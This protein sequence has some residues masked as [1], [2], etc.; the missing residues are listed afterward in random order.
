MTSARPIESIHAFDARVDA[1]LEQYRGNPVADRVFNTAST[2][3]DFSVLW[4]LISAARALRGGRNVR[5]SVELSLLLGAESLIVNQGIKRLFKRTRPTASGD[6]RYGVRTPSTSSFPS[7]HAS[8]AFFAATL[9][10]SMTARRLAPMWFGLALIVAMS[11][12]FVRIHHASD[13][14][15]GAAVGLTLGAI[16]TRLRQLWAR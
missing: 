11:R 1:W 4:H 10:T 15:G 12:P 7:G 14:V 8:S 5:Q 3:G 16:A 2:L 13:I 6:E 9:L